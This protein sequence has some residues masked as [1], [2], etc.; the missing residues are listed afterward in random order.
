MKDGGTELLGG[1]GNLR[2]TEKR[3]KKEGSEEGAREAG[4]LSSSSLMISISCLSLLRGILHQKHVCTLCE[5]ADQNMGGWELKV[6][7]HFCLL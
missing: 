2:Y 4:L 1:G 7:Q 3:K 5:E 6:R